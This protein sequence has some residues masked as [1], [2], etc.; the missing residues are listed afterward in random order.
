MK[1]PLLYPGSL[2]ETGNSTLLYPGSFESTATS[3]RVV[4]KTTLP[5]SAYNDAKPFN[6]KTC[7][8]SLSR[9]SVVDL[10]KH[11]RM[12]DGMQHF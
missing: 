7:F 11:V 4:S 10:T 5:N 1:V 12:I 9:A 8:A 2:P 3:T 6:C